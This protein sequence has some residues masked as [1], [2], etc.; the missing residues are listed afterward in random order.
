VEKS[1]LDKDEIHCCGASYHTE[2][3]I[4]AED[5]DDFNNHIIGRIEVIAE[6]K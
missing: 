4:A 5:L 3:W 1:F 6:Y 2:W